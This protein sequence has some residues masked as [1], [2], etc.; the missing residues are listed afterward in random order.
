MT[1]ADG[2]RKAA[3]NFAVVALVTRLHHWLSIFVEELTNESA[4]TK[5]LVKNL[6]TLNERIEEGP[7]PVSFF[8]SFVT[9]RDSIVHSDNKIEWEFSGK[10]HRVADRTQTSA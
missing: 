7:I 8:E 6:K 10:K 3:N 9:V 4:R 2:L 5:S 1:C